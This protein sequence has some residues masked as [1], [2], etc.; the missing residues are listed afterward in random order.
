MIIII[1]GILRLS[2]LT[3]KLMNRGIEII[4]RNLKVK[5]MK[6]GIKEIIR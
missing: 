1:R 2:N 6:R 3:V 5:V 4:F